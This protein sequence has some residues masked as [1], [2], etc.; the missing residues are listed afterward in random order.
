MTKTAARK[1]ITGL[2]DAG[3]NGVLA[4]YQDGGR[5]VDIIFSRIK[6]NTGNAM[7]LE[8]SERI[9]DKEIRSSFRAMT[10]FSIPDGHDPVEFIND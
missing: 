7:T 2:L 5:K 6:G 1:I 4:E 8:E 9:M 3:R 10:G